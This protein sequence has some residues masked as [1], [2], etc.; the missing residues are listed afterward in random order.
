MLYECDGNN[1]PPTDKLDITIYS[2]A[3]TVMVS[4]E[5]IDTSLVDKKEVLLFDFD[6]TI[7]DSFDLFVKVFNNLAEKHHYAPLS[8]LQAEGFRDYSARELL[9]K[10][11]VQKWKLPFLL[12]EGRKEFEKHFTTLKPFPEMQKTLE[13]LS[14]KYTMGI[15]TSNNDTKVKEFLLLNKID[16][17]Q[18]VYSDKCIF[19]KGKIIKK[20]LDK[21]NFAVKDT[22]YVGDEVRDIDAACEAG[23]KVISVTWGFNSTQ[24]LKRNNPDYLVNSPQEL[25]KLSPFS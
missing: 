4:P 10:L 25:T 21:Y 11:P 5:V 13:Q 12:A 14:Q 6:G 18:F 20:V 8:P 22:I 15:V 16:Y 17:F 24:S 19:G 23:I 2:K 1:F 3:V 9:T 7:A